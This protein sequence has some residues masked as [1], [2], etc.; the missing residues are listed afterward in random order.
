MFDHVGLYASNFERSKAFYGAVL[1]PLGYNLLEDN[2]AGERRWLVFGAAPPPPFFVVAWFPDRSVQPIHFAFSAPSAR[3]VDSFHAAGLAAGG[4]D[5]GAPGPR[6]TPRPH[7]AA[8]LLD[9]DGNNV[10]AG[11]RER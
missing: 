2:Q 4:T 5:N 11:F 1:P 6:A 3:A 7:Y 9:P 10:E 8:F